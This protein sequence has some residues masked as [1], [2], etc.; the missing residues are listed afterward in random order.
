MKTI[1]FWFDYVSP[2]AY[3]AWMRIHALAAR[4]DRQVEPI[5]ILFAALLN[6]NDTRGPAEIPAKRAWVFKDT[7]RTARRHGIP[8][9]PPPTHPFNPLV[10]LRVTTA[11]PLAER[12]PLVDALFAATWGGG[13]GVE[14]P[15]AVAEIAKG[16]GLDGEALVRRI[17]DPEVKDT[18]RRATDDALARG[19]FGVPTMG[20][21]GELFWGLDSFDHLEDSLAGRDTLRPED[22]DLWSRTRP[23]AVRKA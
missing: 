2:Y 15:A 3:L 13:T 9:A 6:H 12:K 16:V 8:F 10:A 5:P 1:E 4:H 19:V 20:A 21:N 11:V 23:S 14:D 17:A 22:F 7:V 18:L